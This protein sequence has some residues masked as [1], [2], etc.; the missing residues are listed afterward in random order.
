ME[1]HGRLG[2][3]LRLAE[4]CRATRTWSDAYGHA[5]VATG[6]VEAMADPVVAAWDISAM[7]LIVREA[8]G[9]FT[10]F[11][12]NPK[13]SNEALSTNVALHGAVMEAFRI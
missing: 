5:L 8:G 12:G 9:R 13:P 4:R 10:G 11:D 6:R 3:L 1:R 7:K 2:P